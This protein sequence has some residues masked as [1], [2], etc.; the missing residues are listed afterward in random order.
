MVRYINPA[1]RIFKSLLKT[2]LRGDAYQ[3]MVR[4]GR[5][6]ALL[7]CFA[8]CFARTTCL[9]ILRTRVV[10][11]SFH[12]TC[13]CEQSTRVVCTSFHSTC[14]CEQSTRVVCTSFHSEPS[15]LDSCLF[16]CPCFCKPSVNLV[17]C[18]LPTARESFTLGRKLLLSVGCTSKCCAYLLRALQPKVAQRTTQ[19]GRN[20]FAPRKKYAQQ[21]T[22]QVRT[23]LALFG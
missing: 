8:T 11:T 1:T 17:A 6:S 18:F 13:L 20:C 23:A 7:A 14:L 15:L 2:F 12:S 9:C 16:R 5:N 10:C 3:L 22:Q 21:S 19:E 4:T